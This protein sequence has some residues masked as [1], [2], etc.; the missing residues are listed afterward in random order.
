MRRLFLLVALPF[1]AAGCASFNED[2]GRPDFI[3]APGAMPPDEPPS[4]E[5][6][7]SGAQQDTRG[8]EV[9]GHGE[10]YE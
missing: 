1:V 6:M 10:G 8:H 2:S 7:K 9:A 3:E 4:E 5:A